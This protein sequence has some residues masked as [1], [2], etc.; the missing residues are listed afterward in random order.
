MTPSN[1]VR[2]VD[3]AQTGVDHAAAAISGQK[4]VAAHGVAEPVGNQ[5]IGAPLRI[6]ALSTNTKSVYVGNDGDDDVTAANGFELL[7][8]GEITYAYVADLSSLYVD[9]EVDGEGVCWTALEVL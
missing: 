2:I 4:L 8:G 5:I 1:P 7:P 3:I 6:K 9:S